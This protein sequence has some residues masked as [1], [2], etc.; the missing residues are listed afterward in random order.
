MKL[1]ILLTTV[2]TA[3][4]AGFVNGNFDEG[5]ADVDT[6]KVMN[7]QNNIIGW[8]KNGWPKIVKSGNPTWGR[9]E[10]SSG[11]HYLA[12]QGPG[13]WVEQTV[14]SLE[15]NTLYTLS[16]AMTHR[17]GQG[18]KEKAVC[19]VNGETVWSAAGA[20]GGGGRD[21]LALLGDFTNQGSGRFHF[22]P[23]S[24]T[25]KSNKDGEATIRFENDSPTGRDQSV[26]LDAVAIN[27]VNI[28]DCKDW[29]CTEWCKWY[30]PETEKE[31]VYTANGCDDD[32]D[33]CSC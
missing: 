22:T 1:A 29:T 32:G 15:A 3:Q 10:S 14:T 23:Y 13:R 28:A 24:V 30:D 6:F 19:V 17:P 31:G 2:A 18:T 21:G 25:V 27:V 9:L 12:I 4:A 16:F 8:T 11:S 26:F 5:V 33:E 7:N 20:A